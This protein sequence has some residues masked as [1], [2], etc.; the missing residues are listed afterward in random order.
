MFAYSISI[1]KVNGIFT[2]K[3][4]NRYNLSIVKGVVIADICSVLKTYG[5]EK[6]INN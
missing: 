5:Y 1:I 6:T 4:H 3:Y 2:V